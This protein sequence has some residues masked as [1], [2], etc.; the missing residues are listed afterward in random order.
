MKYMNFGEK[1]YRQLKKN[2][3]DETFSGKIKMIIIYK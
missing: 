3:S 2:S 1:Y